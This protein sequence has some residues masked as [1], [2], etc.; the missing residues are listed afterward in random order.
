MIRTSTSLVVVG[1]ASLALWAPVANA[2][3]TLPTWVE[4][5]DTTYSIGPD[6]NP[7]PFTSV[8]SVVSPGPHYSF[9]LANFLQHTATVGLVVS[10]L[11]DYQGTP[12]NPT[13]Y[14]T[15]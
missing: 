1:L 11:V 8:D 5:I 7:T 13:V 15:D 6:G 4:E 3:G 10:A 9:G 14:A 2:G 12:I